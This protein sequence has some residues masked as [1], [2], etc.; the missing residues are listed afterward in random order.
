ME[1]AHKQV[2]TGS[3]AFAGIPRAMVY[4]LFRVL[5]GETGLVVTVASRRF[6][7]LGTCI[8]APGP[9]D[10]AVR[11]TKVPLVARH[12]PRPPLPASRS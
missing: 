5:P 1:E 9:H 7:K 2:T 6:E 4:D 11:E 12:P 8:G 3:A 10:F